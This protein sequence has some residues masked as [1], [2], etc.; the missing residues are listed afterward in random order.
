ME[1]Q[2][3]TFQTPKPPQ[4]PQTNPEYIH[5]SGEVLFAPLDYRFL[6]AYY[7]NVAQRN[8]V[9]ATNEIYHIY[10]RSI[11]KEQIF[12]NFFYLKKIFEIIDF[13][14]FP[15]ELRLSEFKKLSNERKK[16]Y[17]MSKKNKIALVE[18]YVFAFMPN[19]YHF[20]LKQAQDRGI[21]K[22]VSNI[23][24]SFAK[25]YNLKNER[26]GSLFNSPFK[27]KWVANDERFIHVSRYIHL[28]PVTAF[29]IEF[30]NL[31]QYLWTSFPI[32][33][34][35]NKN[36]FLSTDFLLQMFSPSN[37]LKFVADQVD[38]QRKLGLIKDLIIE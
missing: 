15:Q 24:N 3:L 31:S 29:M 23:Q 2:V 13:Y 6:L 1:K 34:N 30:K 17:L 7:K 18:I 33:T 10:N 25:I 20:L 5:P 22:F 16:D 11:A 14:R 38:Y 21:I 12:T 26:D 27:G 4:P 28:N 36:S 9:F 19:H 32:Y 8:V 37:Y 35:V